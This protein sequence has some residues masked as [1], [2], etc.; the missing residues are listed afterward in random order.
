MRSNASDHLLGSIATYR[1]RLREVAMPQELTEQSL[2]ATTLRHTRGSRGSIHEVAEILKR[3]LASF[4]VLSVLAP[5]Q[6]ATAHDSLPTSRAKYGGIL[7]DAYYDGL[8]TCETGLP[9]TNEPN[10]KH[11]T[12]SYTGGLGMARGTAWRW[13]GHRNVAKFSPT[14]QV[15]IADRIAFTSW[16]NKKGEKVWRVGPWG[17]TCLRLRPSLQRFICASKHPLV[18]KWKRGC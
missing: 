18:Q 2:R 6:A 15:E 13:S 10:W 3:L 11:S 7:P 17:W 12:R 4:L 1:P 16:V 8:G 5:A 9:G 14:K